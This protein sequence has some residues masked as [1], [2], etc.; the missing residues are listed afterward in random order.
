MVGRGLPSAVGL[1]C[2]CL[3]VPQHL[4]AIVALP[5]SPLPID[6]PRLTLP[7]PIFFYFRSVFFQYPGNRIKLD[8]DRLASILRIQDEENSANVDSNQ[9]TIDEDSNRTRVSRRPVITMV[10]GRVQ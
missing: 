5:N 10:S 7:P 6:N 2:Q 4:P 9:K 3:F 8:R 1:R